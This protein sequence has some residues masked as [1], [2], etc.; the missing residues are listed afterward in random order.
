MEEVLQR[1]VGAGVGDPSRRNFLKG[2]CGFGGE[3]AASEQPVVGAGAGRQCARHRLPP[4]LRIAGLRQGVGRQ[5]GPP[6]S[7]F[8]H[9]GSYGI[10]RNSGRSIRQP[11][12]VEYM[13]Q[14]GR[15][16]CYCLVALRPAYGSETRKKRAFSRAT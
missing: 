13:D 8:Q 9:C 3:R 7:G 11:K 5:G 12:I 15:S 6:R 10:R 4:P 1:S 14:Q 2:V 16:D